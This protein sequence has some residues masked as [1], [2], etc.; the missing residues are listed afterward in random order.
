[1]KKIW[2]KIIAL[3]IASILPV[4]AI[5]HSGRTDSSGGHRD[6]QNK[7][8]L[9]YYHYHCDGHPPH[10]HNGGI[11]PYAPKDRISEINTPTTPKDRISEINMPTSLYI[12]DQV[13]LSWEITYYS[14]SS[15]VSWGSNNRTVLTTTSDGQLTAKKEG[16]AK[17]IANMK[18]GRN[19]YTVIVKPRLIKEMEITGYNGAIESG[20]QLTLAV[21][22]IPS[23]ATY[24][25]VSWKSSN[26]KVASIDS[27]GLV[28]AISNGIATMTATAV[29]GGK[30]NKTVKITVATLCDSIVVEGPDSLISSGSTALKAILAPANLSSKKIV[31]TSSDKNIAT[32]TS[33]G[34]VTAK[35]VDTAK[36]V[37]IIASTKDGS[38]VWGEISILV[39]PKISKIS[40]MSKI[41]LPMSL[42]RIAEVSNEDI[43]INDALTKLSQEE[44]FLTLHDGDIQLYS[45]IEPD[46]ALPVIKWSSSNTKVV[47]IDDNGFLNPLS[48]GTSKV[49]AKSINGISA[50]ITVYVLD[51]SVP[52]NISFNVQNTTQMKV[53]DIQTIIADIF[54]ESAISKISWKS[55]DNKIA[56]VDNGVITALRK[57]IITITA[58][59]DN[60]KKASIKISI[61]E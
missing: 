33:N 8:G 56:H 18:N 28:T 6:N 22:I 15:E 60:G 11:C 31:W 58:V 27:R 43:T 1:M 40:I 20:D 47:K 35:I 7:S 16:T 3:L 5:A 2:I 54:P 26:T 49:T 13:Y 24:K 44:Q 52:H 23:N 34:N 12:G 53:G 30:I 32:V 59:T 19:T 46:D 39:T 10:L 38:G 25:N 14:G 57:G 37:T 41:V 36:K 29:N 48:I 55:S 50:S 42:K 45:V 21:N 17:I 9:G 4:S 51:P 61:L